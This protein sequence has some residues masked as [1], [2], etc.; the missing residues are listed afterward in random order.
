MEKYAI[1]LDVTFDVRIEVCAE[2]E[3]K[4]KEIARRKVSSNPEYYAKT[5]T[6]IDV[7]V[8]DWEISW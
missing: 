8:V 5:G 1:D 3:E 4:A 6:C 2:N 7:G